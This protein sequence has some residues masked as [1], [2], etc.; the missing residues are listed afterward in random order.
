M[1]S[2]DPIRIVV[3]GGGFAGISAVRELGRLTRHDPLVEV[4]LVS[5]E[6]YFL[7]HPLLPEVVSGS[8]EPS[9]ILNPIR[10]FC[11]R[12]QF[13]CATVTGINLEN[14][15]V[16]LMG[17]DA[18][19]VF[20][21]RFDHLIV[22][23]GLTVDASRVPGMA[24]HSLPLKTL[25]DAFHLRNHVLTCLEE[26][27]LEHDPVMQKKR[28][29]L[30]V[31]GGGFSGVE[32]AAEL[33]DMVKAALRYYPRS[34]AVGFRVVLV[35]S[36]TRLLQELKGGL[37]A[38][39]QVKLRQRGVELL[40]KTKVREVTPDGVT[41]SNGEHIGAETVVC[42]VGMAP[43]PLIR[44][45]RM[46]QE[47]GRL[48]VDESLRVRGFPQIWAMGDVALV[49]DVRR[50]GWCPPTAQYA[51][52]QG[53]HCARNVLAA[54]RDRPVRKFSFH[55][56][57]QLAIVGR[58][59]G[60]AQVCGI[61]LSGILAWWLWRSVYLMKLPG[62]R[63]KLRVGI[64]W[65]IELLFSRD[66]TKLDVQ[67]AHS[68]VRAHY[69]EGAIIVRQGEIGDRFYVIESGTV[70]IIH[71]RPGQVNERLGVKTAGESFGELALLKGA[72][73]SATVRCLTPVDV[74]TFNR[75]DFLALVGSLRMFRSHMDEAVYNY[76]ADR[77]LASHSSEGLSVASPE[78]LVP[79]HPFPSA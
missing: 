13:H 10:Q 63:C 53:P 49:P 36:D 38:F 61:K 35:H 78:P 19:R 22:A 7:F 40:L 26:A 69:S 20:A 66:I 41:F 56:L 32:T 44:E 5:N 59:C 15:T 33:N 77:E 2:G 4:H 24:E 23:M 6:N 43:H 75:R 51:M 21:L 47:R 79:P 48:L 65:V 42:T 28:L 12:I 39:A 67:R 50:G 72:P 62:L 11:D 9:H 30:V 73:R 71:E 3:L 16:S 58:H 74:V 70:E 57:G 64:D 68:L 25:G 18:R 1:A 17:A 8:I 52:R 55:G 60:V 76:S 14:Q 54:I 34:R 31:V 27:E 45:S 46:P 29:T 37:A